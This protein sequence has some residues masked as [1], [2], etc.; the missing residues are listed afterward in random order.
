MKHKKRNSQSHSKIS[1]Q[2][3][4]LGE[5]RDVCVREWGVFLRLEMEFYVCS[6][7]YKWG[8]KSSRLGEVCAN[9]DSTKIKFG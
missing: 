3:F 8:F 5:E 4:E 1:L 6:P 9:P 7:M 2:R